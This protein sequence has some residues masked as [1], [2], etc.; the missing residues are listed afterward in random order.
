MRKQC[1]G[2]VLI[3]REVMNVLFGLP[4]EVDARIEYDPAVD[5]YHL[6]MRSDKPVSINGKDITMQCEDGNTVPYVD[7]DFLGRTTIIIEDITVNE[8]ECFDNAPHLMGS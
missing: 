4:E 3:N 6:I 7:S 8:S 1:K 5:A 2:K